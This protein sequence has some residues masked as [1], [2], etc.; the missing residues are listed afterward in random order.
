MFLLIT[1][2]CR[3]SFCFL[4]RGYNFITGLIS[5]P[6]AFDFRW[7]VPIFQWGRRRMWK[8]RLR[9]YRDRPPQAQ[10]CTTNH[11]L[12]SL[13]GEEFGLKGLRYHPVPLF[14]PITFLTR[15]SMHHKSG[16]QRDNQNCT[17]LFGRA[18]WSALPLNYAARVNLSWKTSG[19]VEWW[20]LISTDATQWEHQK[21]ARD[22]CSEGCVTVWGLAGTLVSKAYQC[23]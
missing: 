9:Q 5:W 12:T 10:A 14:I 4:H 22:E 20:Y 1:C 8:C 19:K 18:W 3:C 6:A 16:C 21:E 13:L 11:H 7:G 17:F 23:R 15:N 2:A